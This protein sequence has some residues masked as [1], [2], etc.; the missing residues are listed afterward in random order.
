MKIVWNSFSGRCSDSPRALWTALVA[1]GGDDEHVWLADPDH[2]AGFPAGVATVPYGSDACIAALESADVVVS[3]NHLALDWTKRPG[4][5]YLQTWHGTPFKHIHRDVLWAPPGRLDRLDEDVA[6]W[7]ALVSPSP[8]ATAWLRQAFRWDGPVLETG[9][10]RNDVLLAADRDAVRARVRRELGVPDG[11]PVVLYTPTWR[12]DLLDEHG[13]QDF[14]LHL[15]LDAV[16]P[17]LG[18]AVL[19]LRLHY[20]VSGR[21]GPVTHPGV[22]DVSAH[23]E[24]AELYLAADAMITDY[25]S[26]MFDFAVTG[27]PMA[28]FAY[29]LEHYRDRLRGFY[30]DVD[31]LP[32][33]L[34]STSEEV[35]EVLGDLPGLAS[36]WAADLGRFRARFCSLE[37]G[38]ATERVLDQFFDGGSVPDR[39]TPTAQEVSA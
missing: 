9:Y 13:A 38:A 32:G 22:V 29:D 11:A 37:D 24:V 5:R 8:T 18:E 36:R 27:R 1:R 12:E 33:P 28:F 23:P 2:A 10:P 6:R 20:E 7:D 30:F 34:L 4:A 3:N 26:T 39:R 35:A 17:R 21:L 19:L 15:D 25:S 31:E 16:T 14:A